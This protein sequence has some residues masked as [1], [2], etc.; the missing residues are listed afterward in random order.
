M[1]CART[2]R[3]GILFKLIALLFLVCLGFGIY[4]LRHPI[5]REAGNFLGG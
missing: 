1:R 2:E 3:G 4:L 5:L